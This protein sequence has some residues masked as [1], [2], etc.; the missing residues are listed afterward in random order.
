M[1][2]TDFSIHNLKCG[3]IVNYD[4]AEGE[5]LPA[6]IDW[7]YLK[8]LTE[9]PKGFNLVHS[10]VILTKERLLAFGFTEHTDRRNL[11]SLNK[12]EIQL[13]NGTFYFNRFWYRALFQTE[14]KYLHELQNLHYSLTGVMLSLND[15]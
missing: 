8:W 14:L 1:K 15:K 11:Y 4:T 5:I 3:N 13:M 6:I 2:K 7:Q 10:P 9:D 12:V